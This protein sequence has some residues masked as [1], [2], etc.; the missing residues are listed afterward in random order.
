MESHFKGPC[1]QCS[2]TRNIFIK[3]CEC[4][5]QN[6]PTHGPLAHEGIIN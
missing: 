2:D 6:S 5:R 4:S 1:A 3:T